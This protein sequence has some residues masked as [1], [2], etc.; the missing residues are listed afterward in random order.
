MGKRSSFP[1]I[2]KD[3]YQTIDKRAVEALLPFLP[4]RVKFAEPCCGEGHLIADLEVLGN[5]RCVWASDIEEGKD[6]LTLSREELE[7]A[8]IIITNPPWSRPILH[9]M[10][11]AFVQLKPTWLLFDADWFHTKQAASYVRDL[12]TDFVSVG[13]LVW[14]PDTKISG[15]DNVAWYRFATDKTEDYVKSYGRQQHGR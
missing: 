8:D 1:K 5:H 2:P 14:M 6:A 9:A 10:I 15:K 4:E 3:Q 13:R 7:K 11:P 12:C